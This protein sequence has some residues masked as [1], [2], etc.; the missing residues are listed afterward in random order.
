M[1][2]TVRA[3]GPAV[4][5]S[6]PIAIAAYTHHGANWLGYITYADGHQQREVHIEDTRI[7]KLTKDRLHAG[8][9]H[10]G[11]PA[12][13][14][15]PD[16]FTVTADETGPLFGRKFP[17][18]GTVKYGAPYKLFTSWNFLTAPNT[19]ISRR[20]ELDRNLPTTGSVMCLYGGRSRGRDVHGKVEC[21]YDNS[22]WSFVPADGA[23]EIGETLCK[24]DMFYIAEYPGMGKSRF[25]RWNN[26]IANFDL[27]QKSEATVFSFPSSPVEQGP[28]HSICQYVPGTVGTGPTVAPLLDDGAAI[29]IDVRDDGQ[30]DRMSYQ[31]GG[32]VPPLPIVYQ[33]PVGSGGGRRVSPLPP[34]PT[35]QQQGGF[36][37][38]V[39]LI[40][41]GILGALVVMYVLRKQGCAQHGG[42]VLGSAPAPTTVRI[43]S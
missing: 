41:A 30:G 12:H 11:V 1:I 3:Q 31:A 19:L 40:L 5:V 27:V 23:T 14:A 20:Q 15:L 7:F 38:W 42:S 36:M 18:D 13:I 35:P 39:M 2:H 16:V 8:P 26:E 32:G 21:A 24:D 6:E 4:K 28:N 34:P 9:Q 10:Y 22:R 17:F 25:L 43:V 29:A 37:H 33:P